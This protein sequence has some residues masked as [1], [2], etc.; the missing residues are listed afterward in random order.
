MLWLVLAVFVGAGMSVAAWQRRE[1]LRAR[2]ASEEEV[3]AP[4]P[5]KPRRRS[6]GAWFI[7]IGIFVGLLLLVFLLT[8]PSP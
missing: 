7:T 4:P 2:G 5:K 3:W 8:M 1:A 6:S